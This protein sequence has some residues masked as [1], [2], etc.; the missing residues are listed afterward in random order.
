MKSIQMLLAVFVISALCGI[1]ITSS[2]SDSSDY[3]YK[4]KRVNGYCTNKGYKDCRSGYIYYSRNGDCKYGNKS[5]RYTCNSYTGCCLPR[6]QYSSK[7]SCIKKYE[8]PRNYFYYNNKGYFYYTKTEYYNCKS[9]KGC[10]L[11][12]GYNKG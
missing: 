12:S 6:Y 2:D 9:Y 8:C 5:W 4:Y 11:R 10:C 3:G 7:Y 1:V